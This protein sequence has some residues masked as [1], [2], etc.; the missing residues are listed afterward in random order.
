[1]DKLLV[2]RMR[3]ILIAREVAWEEKKMMGGITFM[4]DDKM[5]FGML[6]RGLLFRIDPQ[7]RDTLLSETGAE[8]ITQGGREMKGYVYVQPEG[9]ETDQKLEFWISRCLA[10]NPRAKSSKKKKGE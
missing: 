10:F 6:K 7:E 5:C 3:N 4:V 1:M 9:Y 8:I 2:E